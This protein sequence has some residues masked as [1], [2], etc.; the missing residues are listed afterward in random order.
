MRFPISPAIQ[1]WHPFLPPVFDTQKNVV[2]ETIPLTTHPNNNFPD[3]YMLT[4]NKNDMVLAVGFDMYDNIKYYVKKNEDGTI[5]HRRVPVA[6][7]MFSADKK[8]A[9]AKSL[10]IGFVMTS[11]NE[12]VL[13]VADEVYLDVMGKGS[14]VI[15]L[16]T[17]DGRWSYSWKVTVSDK[18][19]SF[20][21]YSTGFKTG[22]GMDQSTEKN[23][24]VTKL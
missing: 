9:T 7:E 17:A 13:K 3:K 4:F 16:K 11:S 23:G 5:V 14:S 1:A 12:D 8:I 18:A 2:T 20:A 19:T 6:R 24:F 15:T 21:E 22:I 10:D